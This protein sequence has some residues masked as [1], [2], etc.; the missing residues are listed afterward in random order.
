MDLNFSTISFYFELLQVT[1]RIGHLWQEEKGASSPESFESIRCTV[2]M[3][4]MYHMRR[5][6]NE[7]KSRAKKG[8][9]DREED[10]V[11]AE[12]GA[13]LAV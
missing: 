5:K 4:F 2:L 13:I 3:R 11:T 12:E 7:I 6:K 9:I 8:M 1:V 10:A